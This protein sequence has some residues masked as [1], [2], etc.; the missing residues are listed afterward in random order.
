M[1]SVSG[2]F[3]AYFW[4]PSVMA[5]NTSQCLSQHQI[6]RLFFPPGM[7]KEGIYRDEKFTD[8]A[9]YASTIAPLQVNCYLTKILTA[10]L[11]CTLNVLFISSILCNWDINWKQKCTLCVNFMFY[12]KHVQPDSDQL[13]RSEHVVLKHIVICDNWQKKLLGSIIPTSHVHDCIDCWV[14]D[15]R[16]ILQ[17]Q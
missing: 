12:T 10:V 4:S 16:Y 11:N 15:C 6:H 1:I 8:R 14:A 13:V 7:N 3:Q 9:I 2:Q 17:Y 5:L